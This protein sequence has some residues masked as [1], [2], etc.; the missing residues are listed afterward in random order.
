M[1]RLFLA[2]W[3]AVFSLQTAD[4]FAILLPDQCVEGTDDV[5]SDQCPGNC[6]RCVCCTRSPGVA[7]PIL[8]PI[9]CEIVTIAAVVPPPVRSSSAHPHD[10][11]HIP[12]TA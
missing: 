7:S 2:L 10:I 3:L 6:A 12:K 11:L 8:V 4:L 1:R 5:G 9:R